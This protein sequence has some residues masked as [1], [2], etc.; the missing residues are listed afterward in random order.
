MRIKRL[1]FF[2]IVVVFIVY[3]IKAFRGDDSQTQS[4]VSNSNIKEA[5]SSPNIVA[6]V[7]HVIDGD[8]IKILT[9]NGEDIVRLIGIDSPE[10]V[11]PR[12]PVQC[13]GKEASYKMNQLVFGK[14]I[15]LEADTTQGDRDK[16]GRLLRFIFLDDGTDVNKEMIEM[17]FAFEYTYGLPYKYRDAYIVAEKYAHTN[18]LGLWN[19]QYCGVEHKYGK[20]QTTYAISQ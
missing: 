10:T 8:T 6:R 16:Y 1:S 3:G 17:G 7:T 4:R 13:F 20:W 9:L 18:E 14:S 15:S 5:T 2:F 11:D 19:S 12:K